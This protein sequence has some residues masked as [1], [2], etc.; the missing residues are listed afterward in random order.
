MQTKAVADATEH[1]HKEHGGRLAHAAQ[2]IEV[3]DV[4]ALVE[5][6]F[7]APGSAV[8]FKPE[9]GIE[10][11]GRSIGEEDDLLGLAP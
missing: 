1:S 6:A 8:E 4:E 2:I 9:Q 5:S 10:R 3:A 7:D 11:L